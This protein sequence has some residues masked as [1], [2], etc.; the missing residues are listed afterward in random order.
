M[1]GERNCLH[2]S[3]SD[4]RSLFC[5]RGLAVRIQD[6]GQETDNCGRLADSVG[7]GKWDSFG[8]LSYASIY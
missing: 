6:F 1:A 4:H 8:I 5:G 7:M 3:H 2:R